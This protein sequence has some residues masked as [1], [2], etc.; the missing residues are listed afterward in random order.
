MKQNEESWVRNLSGSK[1]KAGD[2]ND[3]EAAQLQADIENSRKL[4]QMQNV[5]VKVLERRLG[6]MR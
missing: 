3:D 4:G 2:D 5:K 6:G 1:D